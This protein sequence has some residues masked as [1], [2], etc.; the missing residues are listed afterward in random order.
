MGQNC[1]F[2]IAHPIFR[3]FSAL[4]RGELRSKGGG[5]KTIHFNG[6]EQSVEWI[7]RTV[8]SSNQLS[9][10]GVV[11]DV[12]REVSKG[13]MDSE[14]PEAHDPLESMELLTEP[15]TADPRTG[16]QRRRNLLQEYE[17]LFDQLSDDQ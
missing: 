17:Q 1:C 16:E 14:K 6:S 2:L 7:L 4:E 3:A 8:I 5:K 12:C 9:I 13:T 15:P 11:E 10:H